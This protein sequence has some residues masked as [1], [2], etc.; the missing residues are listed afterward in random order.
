V[1]R[2]NAVVMAAQIVARNADDVPAQ[3]HHALNEL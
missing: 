2:E 1:L 3:A